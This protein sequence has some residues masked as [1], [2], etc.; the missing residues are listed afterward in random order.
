MFRFRS[1]LLFPTSS[2]D[3]KKKYIHMIKP[4]ACP[5]LAGHNI[6]PRYGAVHLN[7][8]AFLH[9]HF[10]FFTQKLFFMLH[11]FFP[12]SVSYVNEDHKPTSFKTN[13]R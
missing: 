11:Y 2:N 13:G 5:K 10:H 8:L 7:F 6:F 3:L 4:K 9:L 1:A 12:L